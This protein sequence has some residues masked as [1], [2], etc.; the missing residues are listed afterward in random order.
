MVLEDPPPEL[1]V[2]SATVS[3]VVLEDEPVLLLPTPL[4]LDP[5]DDVD[6]VEEP[7]D[8][9][10]SSPHPGNANTPSPIRGMDRADLIGL[11]WTCMTDPCGVV[12]S[13]ARQ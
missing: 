6:E 7:P 4:E 13:R 5:V 11:P 3:E 10:P 2:E 1:D 8:G 9:A 12:R